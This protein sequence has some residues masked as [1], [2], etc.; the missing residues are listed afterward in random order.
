MILG[1]PFKVPSSTLGHFRY[2]PQFCE[3][4]CNIAF[5]F[6]STFTRGEWSFSSHD[7]RTS[8]PGAAFSIKPRE[9][10]KTVDHWHGQRRFRSQLSNLPTS[11]RTRPLTKSGS[12][13]GFFA[14]F[15]HS[16]PLRWKASWWWGEEKWRLDHNHKMLYSWNGHGNYPSHTI[17][18]DALLLFKKQGTWG[19][20]PCVILCTTV[21]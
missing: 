16:F 13:L 10:R 11:P 18:P 14:F 20:V 4:D 1:G 5:C 12:N 2:P 8:S 9:M 19:S 17:P 15:L 21:I 3:P 7:Y 6:W